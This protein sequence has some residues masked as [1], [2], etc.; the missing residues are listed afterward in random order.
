MNAERLYAAGFDVIP[1]IPPGSP[2]APTST[3]SPAALGKTP[4]VRT[5]SGL[6][7][8]LNWRE[9]K[10][11]PAD[12][13]TW[14]GWGANV[15]IRADRTVGLDLDVADE[16]LAEII[17]QAALAQLGPAPV[18]IGNPPKRL[19]PYRVAAPFSKMRLV[20]R[21]EGQTYLVEW[22]GSGQQWLAA[23]THPTGRRYTWDRDLAEI[24][25]AGLT[26]V[27][28]E[29]A[30]AF[31]GYVGDAVGMIGYECQQIGDGRPEGAPRGD[32]ARL[33]APSIDELR[34]VVELIPNDD[35]FPGRDEMIKMLAAVR[36]AAGPDDEDGCEI[37]AGWVA[38]RN[39]GEGPAAPGED[40]RSLWR[41]MRGPF[42]VGFPW[43]AELARPYGYN[44]APFE[45][46]APTPTPAEAVAD[47]SYLSDQWLAARVVETSRGI[48]R[49]ISAKDIWL[50]WS[51]GRWQPDAE[52]LAEDTIKLALR[53]I[54]ADLGRGGAVQEQ[55]VGAREAREICSSGKLT[56]V[57][58][59]V[60][61]DRAIA[62]AP[63]SLDVNPW[64]LNTPG[65]VVDLTTGR[66][67]P[68]DPNELCTRS[69]SVT[70]DAGGGCR[71][72]LQFLRETTGGDTELVG[73]LQRLGGYALTG[74]TRE[75]Q[76]A[77]IHGDGGNGKGTFLDALM[78]IWGSYHVNAPMETFIASHNDRHPTEL[79]GLVGARVVTAS[80]TEAG[81]RWDEP[82]LKRLTGGDPV[83][84]RGMRENFFTY[85]PQFKLVF[86]GNQRPEIR[87]LDD[88]MR[89]RT[90]LIPFTRKP[91][92]VDLELGAKLRD[93]WPA[94][95]AWF[96]DGCLTWQR[97]G[98]NPPASV[99]DATEDYF[100][101]SDS[102]GA[103]VR[104][105]LA[106]AEEWTETMA[107]YRSWVE[108]GNR[109]G[110]TYHGS[111]QAFSGRL[112][113]KGFKHRRS[114]ATRRAEV[115]GFT[116]NRQDALKGLVVA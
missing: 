72:W 21:R 77:F 59:L 50:V 26:E 56:S 75:Q 46:D 7:C 30:Q 4:G 65:G 79:A 114:P 22:L 14:D 88:A 89:R 9:L 58:R 113:A 8:G 69:T 1:V 34:T 92:E 87:T 49:N 13:K 18:R 25:A 44:D 11:T 85:R 96:I 70:P 55:K 67:A 111:P 83:T 95:L 66:I 41:R 52:L 60:K 10:A 106:P 104:D 107:L 116:L 98:L 82:K 42:S 31:L 36:A 28:Q 100:E 105:A 81:K 37:M 27:T 24:G 64:I 2:L 90:H 61:I 12:A 16:A 63:E 94:I 40:I 19:L 6:W 35:R 53:Q 29:Q 80:E 45:A 57:A 23:G 84:A 97:E 110:M 86:I 93:E 5:A 20:I 33:L 47:P 17:E 54:A 76:Y 91:A 3:L 112:R 73:Y 108:W 32:Q 48:L 101:E 51:V 109:N 78:G 62:V 102:L 74:S 39:D 71:R 99:L 43:L 38:R 115:F 103:W 15:G 68:P